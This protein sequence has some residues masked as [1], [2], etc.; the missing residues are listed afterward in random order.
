MRDTMAPA[1]EVYCS[2]CVDHISHKVE[3]MY[4]SHVI[5]KYGTAVQFTRMHISH[6]VE[7]MYTSH[8]IYTLGTAMQFTCINTRMCAYGH[9]CYFTVHLFNDSMNELDFSEILTQGSYIK[10]IFLTIT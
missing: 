1:R 6:R 2:V 5:Y 9:Y 8:V 10:T 7:W 3:W 4:V